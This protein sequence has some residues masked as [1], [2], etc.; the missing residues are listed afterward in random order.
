[1][2]K[3]V[4]LMK[5]GRRRK[6]VADRFDPERPFLLLRQVDMAGRPTGFVDVEMKDVRA[7]FF[8]HDLALSRTSRHTMHD[9]PIQPGLPE[10]AKG[11]MVRARFE[12]GE[13]MDAVIYDYEPEAP[14][15]FLYP[16]GPLNRAYNLER[17][18]LTR[19]AIREIKVLATPATPSS[20]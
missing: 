12:W 20:S 11:T 7:A 18:Y 5:D 13:V 19:G 10:A 8:V 14:W 15:Y 6:G 16:H 9:A 17:V 2:L 4:V 1:M 3:V